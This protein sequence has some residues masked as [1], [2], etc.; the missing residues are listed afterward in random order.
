ME[1]LHRRFIRLVHMIRKEFG[2][3]TSAEGPEIVLINPDDPVR[4]LLFGNLNSIRLKLCRNSLIRKPKSVLSV[5]NGSNQRRRRDAVFDRVRRTVAAEKLI[6]V[7][8]A[9][10]DVDLHHVIL[11]DLLGWNV[12]HPHI[13]FICEV[14]PVSF[15][16]VAVQFFFG[17]VVR[18]NS[19]MLKVL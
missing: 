3:Q 13:S 5:D 15:S 4:K 10:P 9:G 16:K 8:S 12:P 18:R 2:L 14:P 11:N 1:H 19:L 17:Y 6:L 7:K